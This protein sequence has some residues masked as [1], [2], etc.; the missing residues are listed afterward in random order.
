MFHSGKNVWIGLT[1]GAQGNC[2]IEEEREDW[3][4]VDGTHYDIDTHL[5][6]DVGTYGSQPNIDALCGILIKNQWRDRPCSLEKRY[7]C[8]KAAGE[9]VLNAVIVNIHLSHAVFD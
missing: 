2:S 7:V 9:C 5:W 4:W 3:I 6:S 8:K 1:H